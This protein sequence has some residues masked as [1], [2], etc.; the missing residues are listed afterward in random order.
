[1]KLQVKI[2]KKLT[3]RQ[4]ELLREFEAEE[5]KEKQAGGSQGKAAGGGPSLLDEA[6]KRLFGR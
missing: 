6:W 3:P 2:P 5:Q 1:M 4:M